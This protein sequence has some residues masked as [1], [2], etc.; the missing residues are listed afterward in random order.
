MILGFTPFTWFHTILSLMALVAG[1]VVV[2]ELY[3][4]RTPPAWTATYI[5]SAVLTD[6]TGF[7]FS[8][9]FGA[10]HVV[11]LVSLAVLVPVIAAY[12]AFGLAGPWRWIYAA[13]QAIT[14]YFLVFVLVAQ[15]FKKVPALTALAPT[16]SEP[17]FA[18]AQTVVL[19]V[20]GWLTWSAA[21]TFRPQNA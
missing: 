13:G 11:G 9:P 15:F 4:S 6:I 12:Y 7:G 20:F 19:A 21:R 5:A 18:I 10:S 16:L 8:F 1:F 17:P 3:A 14:L 2:R